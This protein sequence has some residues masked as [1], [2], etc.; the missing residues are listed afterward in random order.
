MWRR[1]NSYIMKENH[2]SWLMFRICV[3]QLCDMYVSTRFMCAAEILHQILPC[4]STNSRFLKTQVWDASNM[5]TVWQSASVT[6]AA[7]ACLG[8]GKEN[9]PTDWALYWWAQIFYPSTNVSWAGLWHTKHFLHYI[10]QQQTLGFKIKLISE[11][12]TIIYNLGVIFSSYRT[13]KGW[14]AKVQEVEN[15]DTST[16]DAGFLENEID[17]MGPSL[18]WLYQCRSCRSPS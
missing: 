11:T 4:T 10:G 14:P 13:M 15:L 16:G 1:W 8:P 9:L 6:V 7:L 3:F 12:E 2:G 5:E 17:R 18:S